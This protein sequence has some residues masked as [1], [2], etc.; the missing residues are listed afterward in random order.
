MEFLFNIT[1]KNNK[2]IDG[3][4]SVEISV[5]QAILA[6]I[7]WADEKGQPLKNY[8]PI[9][10]LPLIDGRAK[11]ITKELFIPEEAKTILCKAT[12]YSQKFT[13]RGACKERTCS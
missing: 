4:F 3:Q 8:L 7:Y 6:T 9:K 12:L 5:P 11:Y 10:S 2:P 1:F 13:R